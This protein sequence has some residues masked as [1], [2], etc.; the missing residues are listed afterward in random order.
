MRYAVAFAGSI[1]RTDDAQGIRRNLLGISGASLSDHR[2]TKN[3][4]AHG[5]E[6]SVDPCMQVLLAAAR[7]GGLDY[8]HERTRRDGAA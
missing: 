2:G 6:P 4:R 5:H 8:S 3:E 1:C 7:N